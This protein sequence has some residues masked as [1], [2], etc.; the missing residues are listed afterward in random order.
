M[1]TTGRGKRAGGTKSHSSESGAVQGGDH[2]K[3]FPPALAGYSST[4]SAS[5]QRL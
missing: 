1:W 2:L 5:E 3:S 4:L